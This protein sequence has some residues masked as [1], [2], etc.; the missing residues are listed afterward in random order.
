MCIAMQ[1][2][3]EETRRGRQRC[4]SNRGQL[5]HRSTPRLV[6]GLPR[7]SDHFP[8]GS[9]IVGPNHRG[10]CVGEEVVVCV[11]CLVKPRDLT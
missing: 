6:G 2:K 10:S 5:I 9:L 11:A 7:F 8:M 1:G 4:D 3:V